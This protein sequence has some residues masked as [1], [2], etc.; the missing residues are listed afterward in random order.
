MF[1]LMQLLGGNP[2]RVIRKRFSEDCIERLLE[3]KWWEYGPDIL[4]GL[5]IS[6]PEYCINRLEDRI[7][8]RKYEK[9]CPP[10]IQ[11]DIENNRILERI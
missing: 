2:A 6:K 4:S 10:I 7:F 5:D 9:Y 1:R 8:S 3:L 11:L